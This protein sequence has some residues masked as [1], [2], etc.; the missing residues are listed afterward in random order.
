MP[1]KNFIHSPIRNPVR[2]PVVNRW[3]TSSSAP[4]P[5]FLGTQSSTTNVTAPS[6]YT[7]STFNGGSNGL[8]T[9]D[10]NRLIIVAVMT[11]E[12]AADTV[13]VGGTSASLVVEQ[14]T[15]SPL[16]R[17]YQCAKPT[18][19]TGDI[20]VTPNAGP[21]LRIAMAAWAIYPSS[22]TA[23]ASGA[24]RAT[25]TTAAAVSNID[26]QSGGIM[27]LGS[28]SVIST[29]TLTPS[30]TG[31]ESI[32]NRVATTGIEASF[33]YR[34]DDFLI[35]ASGT[36]DDLSMTAGDSGAKSLIVASWGA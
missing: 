3:S 14:P 8:G 25:L 13:T 23:R 7:F 5:V 10:A 35:N 21:M 4:S 11:G 29:T 33:A 31:A 24:N 18:G 27:I 9:E 16:F 1:I 15:S 26:V 2:S 28:A 12:V 22:P 32:N 6:T 36:T 19:P 20:V 30:W 34:F 17:I